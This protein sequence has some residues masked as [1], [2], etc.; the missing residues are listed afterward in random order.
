MVWPIKAVRPGGDNTELTTGT[1]NPWYV[2]KI[3][4]L[5]ICAKM[6][7]NSR[8]CGKIPN[9]E[10]IQALILKQRLF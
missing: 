7:Q 8:E 10:V 5:I 1:E 9:P 3:A 4:S 6:A 2:I